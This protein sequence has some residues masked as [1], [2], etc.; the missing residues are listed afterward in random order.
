MQTLV[1]FY[2]QCHFNSTFKCL[3]CELN[4]NICFRHLVLLEMISFVR[5]LKQLRKSV[6]YYVNNLDTKFYPLVTRTSGGFLLNIYFLIIQ[7]MY[8]MEVSYQ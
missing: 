7:F 1:K 6:L 8:K 2:H 5:Y 4:F 3:T